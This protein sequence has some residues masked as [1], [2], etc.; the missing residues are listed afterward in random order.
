MSSWYETARRFSSPRS[1]ARVIHFKIDDVPI[2]GGPGKGVRG[3][4]LAPNDDVLGAI[5]LGRQSDACMSSMP[6][7]SL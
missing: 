1:D 7:T 6:T 2:L 5:Q 4:K 3:I